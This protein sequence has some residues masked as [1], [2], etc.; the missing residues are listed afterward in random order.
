MSTG[1]TKTDLKWRI[2]LLFGTLLVATFFF[3]RK[4]PTPSKNLP[5]IHQE[6]ENANTVPP[7]EQTTPE[8]KQ[9]RIDSS[10]R[11]MESLP[12]DDSIMDRLLV[13]IRNWDKALIRTILDELLS[14]ITP[15]PIPDDQ[16]AAV[17][18]KKAFK[19]LDPPLIKVP[20]ITRALWSTRPLSAEQEKLL[21]DYLEKNATAI[22]LIEEGSQRS[23]FNFGID[24]RDLD[25]SEFHYEKTRVVDRLQRLIFM[26]L[27]LSEGT[28][29]YR[30][31]ETLRRMGNVYSQDPDIHSQYARYHKLRVSSDAFQERWSQIGNRIGLLAETTSLETDMQRAILGDIYQM[32]LLSVEKTSNTEILRWDRP[33]SENSPNWANDLELLIVKYKEIYNLIP[34]PYHEIKDVIADMEIQRDILPPFA[35]VTEYALP[36]I[37]YFF[38]SRAKAQAILD[39][40]RIAVAL[41]KH[42]TSKGNY[43]SSLAELEA[44]VPGLT[45][46]PF[47]GTPYR[48]R[49]EGNGFLLYSV[50]MDGLD[51][52]GLSKES[53]IIFRV[54]E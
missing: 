53:D 1:E 2:P 9:T 33:Y 40:Q 32:T 7:A 3:V 46:D 36:S 34:Q 5:A 50:G 18:Y 15:E 21:H 11:D 24:W 30:Y 37:S 16:N 41:E 54:G 25:D 10:F 43:P 8:T 20:E 23:G 17:L 49:R 13:A 6:T 42:R 47:T 22:D 52:G 51:N 29:A 44:L 14:L 31:A 38:Q 28:D 35:V 19:E 48:Y 12:Q 45:K 27:R 4:G 39:T 26:K